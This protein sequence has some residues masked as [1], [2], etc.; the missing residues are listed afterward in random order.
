ML[1]FILRTLEMNY[2]YIIIGNSAS[3]NLQLQHFL[4]E[5]NDFSCV[6]ISENSNVALNSILKYS[7]DIIFVDLQKN[8]REYFQMVSDLHQY[9]DQIPLIIALAPLKIMPM[10]QLKMVFLTTGYYLIMSLILEKLFLK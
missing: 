9:I 10:M 1:S 7:P 2:S 6:D 5:Y 8:T 3:S 4:E